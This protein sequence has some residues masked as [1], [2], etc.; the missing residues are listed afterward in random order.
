MSVPSGVQLDF[1]RPGKH[2]ENLSIAHA[3]DLI[4]TCSQSFWYSAFAG[5][6]FCRHA[7]KPAGRGSRPLHGPVPIAV[8]IFSQHVR[9]LKLSRSVDIVIY[10][11]IRQRRG[12]E[13]QSE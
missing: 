10:E 8:P 6:T 12:R 9:S 1:I 5:L 13:T 4:A 2:V 7:T 3:Q 11:M